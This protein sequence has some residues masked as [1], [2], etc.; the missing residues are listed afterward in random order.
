[1]ADKEAVI[2][3]IREHYAALGIPLDGLSDRDVEVGVRQLAGAARDMGTS[4]EDVNA[5][6]RQAV[7]A[8]A[9]AAAER[10][11]AAREAEESLDSGDA[12]GAD[13]PPASEEPAAKD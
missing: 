3:K 7:E 11:A 2:A 5:A 8:V 1:M 6:M 10:E 13:S 4:T 9:K 12:A